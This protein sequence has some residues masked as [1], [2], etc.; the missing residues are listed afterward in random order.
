VRKENL[1]DKFVVGKKT[2][3]VGSSDIITGKA[4]YCADLNLPGTLVGKLLYSDHPC[5]RIV[6]MDVSKAQALTGVAA[7]LTYKDIPGENSYLYQYNDQPLLVSD[8]VRYQGDILVALAAED[9]DTARAA[10]DAIKIEYE[11]LPGVFDP[12]EAMKSDSTRVWPNRDNI[13]SHFVVEHGD[14]EAGFNQADL[15]VE[16]T[17]TTQRVEHAFLEP[18][19]AQA[20]LADDGM[21]VVYA[22]SQAPYSDRK[23]IARSLALPE[24][25]VRVIVPYLGG[26]FGGK[27]EATVQIHAALLAYKTGRPV[28]VQR[29]REESILTHVKRHGMIIHYRSG[30]TRDGLLT[31]VQFTVIGDTGPY[32][33][34]GESVLSVSALYGFGPYNIPNAR[35]EAYTVLTNNPTCGAFRGFGTPQVNFAYEQQMDELANRLDIDPMEIRLRNAIKTGTSLPTGFRVL[36]GR[37]MVASIKEVE[38]LSCWK[39]RSGIERQPAYHLR[40]GWGVGCTLYT[41]GYGPNAG[42]HA[43]A[44]L[45]MT[46]DGSVLLRTG[47]VDMG[48]GAHTVLAQY[49]A[50]VLGVETSS[51]KVIRPD[52][53]VTPDAGPS[54]AS[55]TTFVS[56][57]AVIKASEPIRES[58]LRVASQE[59]GLE[60]NILSLRGGLLYAENEELLIT[61]SYLAE[62]AHQQGLQMCADGFYVVE[63]PGDFPEDEDPNTTEPYNFATHVA[64]VLVDIETGEVT[65]EDYAAVH[66]SGTII[67]PD[68]GMGQITGGVVQGLGYSLMEDLVVDQGRTQNKSLESY[69]IPT[70]SDFPNIKVGLVEFPYEYGP[71]GAK[72][73]GEPPINPVSAAVANAVADAIGARVRQLPITA[74][75]VLEALDTHEKEAGN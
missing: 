62:K 23:Q 22:S 64:R 74:E 39:E 58:L 32:V 43:G 59:T 34:A 66:E 73:L 14:I 6:K 68:G 29:T 28:R 10:L 51:I 35:S 70:A 40:R 60:K 21:L 41:T 65:V 45:D 15:I 17:Y 69:L 71:L 12:I 57:H 56:G 72:G 25:K 1:T 4:R 47:A 3:A 38:R 33:N 48:Q 44:S 36:D 61:V 50:E 9:E 46:P 11:V 55:R 16:N 5:A 67:N 75:R 52:T 19:N 42:D 54:V 13:H 53:Q 37:G 27:I 2:N 49:A 24:N 26:G 30:A 31:A 18:E 7:V 8:F 20:Y 63:Y